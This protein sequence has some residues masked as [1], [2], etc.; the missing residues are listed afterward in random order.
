MMPS[1]G[2]V[3]VSMISKSPQ[4]TRVPLAHADDA[5]H[6]VH[7]GVRVV[8]LLSGVDVLMTGL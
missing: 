5:L 4:P 1:T 6:P 8:V 2:L 3:P 7:E